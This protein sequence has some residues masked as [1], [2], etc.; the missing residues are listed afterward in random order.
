MEKN[1]SRLQGR[2]RNK[3][4]ATGSWT[5]RHGGKKTPVMGYKT[6]R[7]ETNSSREKDIPIAWDYKT[8]NVEL[9]HGEREPDREKDRGKNPDRLRGAEQGIKS[10]GQGAGQRE[11]E[12]TGNSGGC[13]KKR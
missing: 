7:E 10:W 9:K 4:T 13:K 5:A 6:D 2:G 11:M 8:E 3:G 1:S 12:I